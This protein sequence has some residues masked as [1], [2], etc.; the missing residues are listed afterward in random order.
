MKAT[1]GTLA[2]LA[3]L[4]PFVPRVALADPPPPSFDIDFSG[5][6][7]IWNPFDDFMACETEMGATGCS[8]STTLSATARATARATPSSV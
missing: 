2:L 8:R 7:S 4:A 1:V 3:V 6:A 5:D